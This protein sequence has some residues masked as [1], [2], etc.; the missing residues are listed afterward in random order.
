MF[1]GASGDL[2]YVGKSKSLRSRIRAH[3]NASEERRF[4][5][6][7]RKIEIQETAGELGALLLESK[8]I[9]ELRPLRNIAARRRRRII[10]AVKKLNKQGFAVVSLK[11]IDYWSIDAS[12]PVLGLFKHRTQAMEYLSEV[13]RAY[14]LCPKLLKL[15]QPK[16]YCF[17]YHLGRCDGA[18]MGDG[19][20]DE[21]NARLDNAFE[22]RRI[23]AWPYGGPIIVEEKSPSNNSRESFLIDNWCLLGSLKTNDNQQRLSAADQHRF[24]YDSYKILYVYLTDHVSRENIR[25]PSKIETRRFSALA[26]S[27]EINRRKRSLNDP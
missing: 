1:Y 17:S 13:A 3:F 19:D 14:R 8:Y 25:A 20:P 11:A 18:C 12:T 5:R 26:A 7:V 9:K 22:A 4:M 21:Y 27:Q 15:E 24:D 6:G 16:R 2:L 23:K 10:I